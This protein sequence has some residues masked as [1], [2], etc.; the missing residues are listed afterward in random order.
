MEIPSEYEGREQSYLKHRVLQEYL[1][2]WSHK[3]GSLGKRSHLRLWYVDCFAGPWESRTDSL[4]DTSI[5]IGL[6]ALEEAALTWQQQGFQIDAGAIFVEKNQAAYRDLDQFLKTHQGPV[7]TVALHGNFGDRVGEICRILKYDPAFVFVD[8]TGFKGAA[9]GF[10]PQLLRPRMRDVLVNVM[11]DHMNRF[12]TVLQD[13]MRDFFNLEEDELPASASEAEIFA[14]YRKRLKE[15]CGLEVA[16]DLRV[17]HPEKDRTWFRLVIG[18]KSPAV[19]E[20]FRRVEANILGREAADVRELVRQ[21]KERENSG[22]THLFSTGPDLEPWYM[23]QNAEDRERTRARL[24]EMVRTAGPVPWSRVWPQL[25]EE[26]HLTL[27]EANSLAVALAAA[28]ELHIEPPLEGRRRTLGEQHR[29]VS[30]SPN[31]QAG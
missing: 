26:H 16:A 19:L 9:M 11:F 7:K 2:V 28:G 6:K 1:R 21:R 17:P 29:L 31:P 24:K 13:H 12:R 18:G 25:L 14:L 23:R 22:Q 15:T 20:V 3:I 30:V 5:H 8:P 10:L 4:T 27:P